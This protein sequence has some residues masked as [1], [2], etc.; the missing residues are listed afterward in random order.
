MSKEISNIEQG[1]SNGEGFCLF[2]SKFLVQYSKLSF[3]F[4]IQSN[5]VRLMIGL[6]S[7]VEQKALAGLF[8]G[9]FTVHIGE[10]QSAGLP[11]DGVGEFA[12]LGIGGC[13]RAQAERIFPIGQL[14]SPD[15][16]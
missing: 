1:I 16:V 11:L 6:V 8:S 15:A 7:L 4:D 14:A 12:G 10:I 9:R 3:V 13:Q 5:S 2:H